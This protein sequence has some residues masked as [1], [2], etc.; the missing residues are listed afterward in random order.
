MGTRF[1]VWLLFASLMVTQLSLG[2]DVESKRVLV[3]YGNAD[4]SPWIQ[5][6]NRALAEGVDAGSTTFLQIEFLELTQ[7]SDAEKLS[8]AKAIFEKSKKFPPDL[9]VGVLPGAND[10]LHEYLPVLAPDSEALYVLPG[11]RLRLQLE[12]ENN[13][14][15][16]NSY[17]SQASI[18]TRD[19]VKRLFPKAE[20]LYYIVGTSE[21]NLTYYRRTLKA[22]DNVF[23]EDKVKTLSGY[24]PDELRETFLAAPPNSVAVYVTVDHDRFGVRY[25]DA[26]LIASIQNDVVPIFGI[27]DTLLGSGVIGGSFTSAALYGL[28]TAELVREVLNLPGKV[29]PI[30]SS[31][32]QLVVDDKV[33]EM[34]GISHDVLPD[35]VT[36]LNHEVTVWQEYWR[37]L[38][39]GLTI[40]TLQTLMILLLF[41]ESQRRKR[42]ERTTKHVCSIL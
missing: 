22:F 10:F 9:V 17:W 28:S 37:E 14:N 40:I 21:G 11:E 42:T 27:Q 4:L 38:L 23:D 19:L 41:A 20:H 32:T 2:Q 13:S 35:D 3:I 7:Y 34:F 33:L 12:K 36:H 8:Y 25:T 15:I 16:V 5:M 18:E 6:Y 26:E 29:E 30:N 24:T 39:I 31:G 1:K